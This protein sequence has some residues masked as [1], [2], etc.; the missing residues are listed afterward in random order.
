MSR[1]VHGYPPGELREYELKN[2]SAVKIWIKT[3]TEGE[4]RRTAQK[5]EVIRVNS[6]GMVDDLHMVDM[7]RLVARQERFVRGFVD[8]VEGYTDAAG[9]AIATGDDLAEHGDAE[10]LAE[11]ALEV[12]R[13]LSLEAE[14]VKKSE[15]SPDS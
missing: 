3:P 6:E 11:V 8:K 4:K 13:S 9:N 1:Q 2:D 14:S 5:G 12:E 10:I 15:A 7:E